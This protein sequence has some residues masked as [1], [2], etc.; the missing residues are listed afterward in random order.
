M[1]AEP[2]CKLRLHCALEDKRHSAL[3]GSAARALASTEARRRR[4]GRHWQGRRSAAARCIA[5]LW[6]PD[7]AQ[8]GSDAAVRVAKQ[9]ERR[10]CVRAQQAAAH[11]PARIAQREHRKPLPKHQHGQALQ[12][13][14]SPHERV[15]ERLRSRGRVGG[16]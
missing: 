1:C 4:G 3:V 8:Q 11:S 12:R 13:Q 6:Q 9:P 15:R 10:E 2:L 16:V 14:A 5:R 7:T